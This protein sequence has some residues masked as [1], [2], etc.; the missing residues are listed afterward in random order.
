[1]ISYYL[2]PSVQY[3]PGTG[4]F[5]LVVTAGGLEGL[6]MESLTVGWLTLLL[7]PSH[8][9]CQ[10]ALPIIQFKTKVLKLKKMTAYLPSTFHHPQQRAAYISYTWHTWCDNGCLLPIGLPTTYLRCTCDCYQ[11]HYNWDQI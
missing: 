10:I 1:M 8:L 7:V 5:P 9:K 3:S 6:I 4:N 11:W 2:N